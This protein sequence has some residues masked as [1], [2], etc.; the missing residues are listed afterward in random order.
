VGDGLETSGVFKKHTPRGRSSTR[1]SRRRVLRGGRGGG[2]R[3][4]KEG[5]RRTDGTRSENLQRQGKKPEN[6]ERLLE[7]KI[8]KKKK[9]K[10]KI[11][12]NDNLKL[13]LFE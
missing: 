13:I 8:K 2:Y 12:K 3:G 10:P 1:K 5:F 7:G 6:S 11:S 9:S 4:E